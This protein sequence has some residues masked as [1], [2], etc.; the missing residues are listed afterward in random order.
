MP[1]IQKPE[2]IKKKDQS[3]TQ[4]KF[5]SIFTDTK[6]FLSKTSVEN[7][8]P[9]FEKTLDFPNV[10]QLSLRRYQISLINSRPIFISLSQ[11]SESFHSIYCWKM[12]SSKRIFVFIKIFT[13]FKTPKKTKKSIQWRFQPHFLIWVS[14]KKLFSQALRFHPGTATSMHYLLGFSRSLGA[15]NIIFHSIS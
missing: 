12:S 6:V 7:V 13:V 9:Y 8:H 15:K 11:K 10:V 1:G 5:K 14:K 4:R 3:S 2:K